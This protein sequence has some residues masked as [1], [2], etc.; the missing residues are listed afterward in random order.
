MLEYAGSQRAGLR[1]E[2]ESP[3]PIAILRSFDWILLGGVAALVVVGLWGV[4]GITK[5]AIPGDPSY[6]LN[7]QILYACVGAV[8]LVAAALI[9]PDLYRR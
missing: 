5:F 6:Y 9:D 1:S 7:R 4:A 8:A 2:R 3:H